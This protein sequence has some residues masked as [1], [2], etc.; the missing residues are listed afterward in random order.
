MSTKRKNLIKKPPNRLR[1]KNKR[2]SKKP[3]KTVQVRVKDHLYSKLKIAARED[4]I[5]ISKKLDEV[6]KAHFS[7]F[8]A[9]PIHILM[10]GKD[11]EELAID[12]IRRQLTRVEKRDLMNYFTSKEYAD[13]IKIEMIKE[14]RE[15][16]GCAPSDFY[17][18]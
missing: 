7:M 15:V 13:E 6:V 4:Q 9:Y 18:Y 12:N 2:I 8:K 1:P 17:T 14:M 5:T 16:A 3:R 11:I 10:T